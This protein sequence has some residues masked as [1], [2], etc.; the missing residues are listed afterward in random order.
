MNILNCHD[1]FW[2]S[3]VL[4]FQILD[5]LFFH[6]LF[7]RG[8]FKIDLSTKEKIKEE[9][10]ILKQNETFWIKRNEAFCGDYFFRKNEKIHFRLTCLT[11]VPLHLSVWPSRQKLIIHKPL[12][13]CSEHQ[14]LPK[15]SLY[16]NWI[17]C[18]KPHYCE[19]C[20]VPR[21]LAYLIILGSSGAHCCANNI[22]EN[23][24][25]ATWPII[26]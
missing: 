7:G 21:Y 11:P 3:Q 4:L 18:V 5:A 6:F 17:C 1:S 19:L 15:N 16:R 20:S 24:E 2:K 25:K 10:R 26:W 8:P 23:K 14:L 12:M 9:I 13:S 22:I